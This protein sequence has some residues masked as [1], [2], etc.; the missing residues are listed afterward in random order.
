MKAYRI[1]SLLTLFLPITALLVFFYLTSNE[2]MKEI[3]EAPNIVF[4]NADKRYDYITDA[5]DY[6]SIDPVEKT[7]SFHADVLIYE[8]V[9]VL[10]GTIKIAYPEFFSMGNKFYAIDENDNLV[11]FDAVKLVK[12][13]MFETNFLIGLSIFISLG[14]VAFIVLMVIKKMQVLSRHRR[15]SVV[16]SSWIFTIFFLILYMISKQVYLIFLVFSLSFT[17]Y[18]F[19]WIIYRKKNGLPLTD[20]ISQRVVVT[21]E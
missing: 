18:Y 20:Q 21:N 17:A 12:E 10:N 15:L 4:P 13:R 8:D 6:W 2:G 14:A 1:I 19:E 9:E 3:L 11:L 7:I 16:I 5:N